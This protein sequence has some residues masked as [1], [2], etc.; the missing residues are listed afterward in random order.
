MGKEN[1]AD[2]IPDFLYLNGRGILCCPENR[3]L[4]LGR[5]YGVAKF[6]SA[7]VGRAKSRH[8]EVPTPGSTCIV[9][10]ISLTRP[11]EKCYS[12]LPKEKIP[13]SLSAFEPC[14]PPE[15]TCLWNFEPGRTAQHGGPH[16]APWGPL[17]IQLHDG[18][19]EPH[20]VH[21]CSEN[22]PHFWS[23]GK[24]WTGCATLIGSLAQ[25]T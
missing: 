8:S 25:H 5:S 15:T 14:S 24:G 4:P 2:K 20:L 19:I 21:K 9:W 17:S 11:R 22:T 13:P 7:E 16:Q 3:N 12:Y 6:S 23:S 10:L 1:K 18:M